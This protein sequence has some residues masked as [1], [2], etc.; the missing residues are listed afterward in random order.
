MDPHSSG[1]TSDE[2]R[3]IELVSAL[4]DDR[5]TAEQALELESLV[6]GVAAIRRLYVSLMHLHAGLHHYASALGTVAGAVVDEETT[7]VTP[8]VRM[9]ETMLLP[10]LREPLDDF[11]E[12]PPQT[13]PVTD[14]TRKPGPERSPWLKGGIAAV[15][16]MVIGLAAFF[17]TISSKSS[18]RPTPLPKV[19]VVPE[20]A[21]LPAVATIDLTSAAR[22]DPDNVNSGDGGFAAGDVLSLQSGLVQLKL[23]TGGKVVAEGPVKIRFVSDTQLA[24]DSGKLAANIPGGG[25]VIKCPTGWVTDLGTEFGVT[26]DKTGGAEVAVFKGRVSAALSSDA[27]TRG[28]RELI[29]GQA[30]VMSRHEL[31]DSP[32][33]AIKQRYVCNLSN[34]GVTRLDLTDLISGGDGTT[35]NR[36]IAVDSLTGTIGPRTP[37]GKRAADGIYHKAVGFPVIDGAFVPTATGGPMVVDSAGDRFNFERTTDETYN[38]IWTGGKIP[39][40]DEQGI[41]TVIDG[42]DMATPEHAIICTH[43]NNAITIDL[44]AIRRLYPDRNLTRFHCTFAN[45]YVNGWFGAAKMN[46]V[47]SAIVL[48]DGKRRYQQLGF[49]N[50]DHGLAVDFPLSKQDRFMTLVCTDAGTEIDHDWILWADGKIDLSTGK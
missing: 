28:T 2:L 32:E 12:D 8:E 24:L 27:T 35:H 18:P 50:Q 40:P 41:S 43:A 4:C 6:R 34:A 16:M 31:K 44:D 14:Y 30:V 42:V 10:A 21:R 22:F 7:G 9:G 37:I 39:W 11:G 13:L 15:L 25:L 1:F 36:G 23:R 19:A 46:P 45:S 20:S 29:A 48:V 49:T 47:A 3:A 26:V 17:A 38:Y 33:G 5:M